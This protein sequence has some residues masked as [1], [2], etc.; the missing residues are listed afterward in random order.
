MTHLRPDPQSTTIHPLEVIDQPA[1]GYV[2][3]LVRRFQGCFAWRLDQDSLRGLLTLAARHFPALR[4]HDCAD[5][6][7]PSQDALIRR[8]QVAGDL[9]C[10]RQE[11]SL[12]DKGERRCNATFHAALT[13][14]IWVKALEQIQEDL[15]IFAETEGIPL[16]MA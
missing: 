15:M 10:D 13:A 12:T 11:L 1:A 9:A 2:L 5:R 8:L 3:D 7:H 14:P 16:A 6:L 4:I